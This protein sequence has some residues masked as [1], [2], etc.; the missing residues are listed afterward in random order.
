MRK[1]RLWLYTLTFS[2]AVSAQESSAVLN[3]IK[4]NADIAMALGDSAQ[5]G[6]LRSS[7][8]DPVIKE[9]LDGYKAR[10]E[11]RINDSNFHA[12]RCAQLARADLPKYYMSNVR[13][14]ALRAGNDLV[15]GEYSQWSRRLLGTLD[16]V[17]D[18]A[19]EEIRRELPGKY[20]DGVKLY[21][22]GTESLSTIPGSGSTF[23]RAKEG[24]SVQR[25]PVD[26]APNRGPFWVKAKVNGVP[27]LF[28]L[29]TGASATVIGRSTARKLA[30]TPADLG[31]EVDYRLVL[32]GESFSARFGRIHSLQL[33]DFTAQNVTVLISYDEN[34]INII[35]LDLISSMG[36]LRFSSDRVTFESTNA[37]SG[38]LRLASDLAATQR[39][40]VGE[41]D[42]NG[43]SVPA[44]IDTG[45]GSLLLMYGSGS[46]TLNKR[47]N[48]NGISGSITPSIGPH[49]LGA[50]FNLGTEILE[51]YDMLLNVQAAQFCL[52]EKKPSARAE[53]G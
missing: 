26:K 37:C 3:P 42:F 40:I 31:A 27:D 14:R 53:A 47:V 1:T 49:P 35:G 32:R 6:V 41:I 29:D 11:L 8:S 23:S 48:V 38:E 52:V 17:V 15:N 33:G 2:A 30:L 36:G 46:N 9:L 21:Y 34:A 5:L 20:A 24:T 12:D 10:T 4:D 18:F 25:V 22:P 43:I 28:A 7:A 16:D 45:N 44:N 13:C 39:A 19:R 50:K 51:S